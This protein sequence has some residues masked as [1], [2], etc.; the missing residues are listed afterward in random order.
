M[1]KTKVIDYSDWLGASAS[2]LCLIHCALTPLIFVTKPLYFGMV[3]RP[4]HYHGWWAGL[5]YIFLALSLLAVWY[6][7]RHTPHLTLR[8]VLWAAWVVFAVGLLLE[9]YELILGQGLMYTGSITLVVAHIKNY[10]YCQQHCKAGM[11]N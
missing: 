11:T 4:V 10:F 5:D 3:G 8:W 7:A 9:P 1:N 2:A 6:S